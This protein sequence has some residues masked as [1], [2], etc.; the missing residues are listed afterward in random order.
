[1]KENRSLRKTQAVTPFGV[2]AIYDVLGESFVACD[3]RRWSSSAPR[4][5]LN[6]LAKS[7]NVDHFIEPP[8]HAD[9][10]WADRRRM[11]FLRFPQWLFCPRCRAMTRWS[12]PREEG[13]DPGEPPLCQSCPGKRALVP[14]RFVAVC[15]DGHL[16]DVPWVR[17]AH[18]RPDKQEQKQ[19]QDARLT[20]RTVAGAGGGLGSLEVRCACG[21]A[22]NLSGISSSDSLKTLRGDFECEGRQAW[23]GQSDAGACD[24]LPQ[25]LQRGASNVY[26]SEMTSA[27][28]IPPGSNFDPNAGL[29]L[30]VLADPMFG[31]LKEFL[32]AGKAD[33]AEVMAAQMAPRHG[34]DV[35][36]VLDI[37]AGMSADDGDTEEH[38]L[39]VGEWLAFMGE[40]CGSDPRDNFR[41]RRAVLVDDRSCLSPLG[42]QLERLVDRVVLATTLR[43]VRALRGF[44]RF[45]P[46]RA[47]TTPSLGQ[48]SDALP[49]IEVRGEGVFV[50][51]KE[52][53]LAKWEAQDAVR[54]RV[55]PLQ[56]RKGGSI[57]GARLERSLTPRLVML[58]TLAHMLIRQ[59]AFECGYSSASL[60]ELVYATRDDSDVAMAGI[61]IYTAAGDS[62]GTLGGLVRQGKSPRLLNTLA[63]ALQS[64]MWCS[65]D[66]ICRESSGQGTDS[67]NL[68]ACHA[69]SLV[70]ETSC[71]YQ[72]LYLDRTLV[73]DDT[74]GM[75]FFTEAVQPAVAA[76]PV[77][78]G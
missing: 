69:C 66:P 52:A 3:T 19:C 16:F 18:S 72:N 25:V 57:Y 11:P 22:R 14:M 38:P 29:T 24:H 27:L 41:T 28:D 40:E 42:S 34:V 58:H 39:D 4:L 46:G 78:I 17:W 10:A 7:L 31:G 2:G 15:P 20:F 30:N 32:N 71:E 51:F 60:G 12:I 59:L 70:S 33:F 55:A 50:A 48:I 26:F 56:Q 47:L 77:V 43:Q 23:Q 49:A 68:A 9:Q 36:V 8:S 61:L 5:R 45:E 76:P 75:G 74:G 64:A 65:S 63:A 35:A 13:L 54:D 21:A 67:L 73:V 62:E 37:A 53:A 6:R 1:M 44:T